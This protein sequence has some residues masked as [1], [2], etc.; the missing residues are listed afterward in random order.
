MFSCHRERHQQQ[1]NNGGKKRNN[2]KVMTGD[3]TEICKKLKSAVC[4]KQ[5]HQKTVSQGKTST[6]QGCESESSALN[7]SVLASIKEKKWEIV[8]SQ[9]VKMLSPDGTFGPKC[10]AKHVYT[11]RYNTS[12]DARPERRLDNNA[13]TTIATGHRL[14][15]H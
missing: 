15:D 13:G 3:R 8:V 4:L 2:R 14:V 6:G 9:G 7:P 1:E 5:V 12:Y 11:M 10:E